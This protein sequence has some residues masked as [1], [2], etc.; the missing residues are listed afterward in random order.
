MITRLAKLAN[1]TIKK[2]NLSVLALILLYY[3]LTEHILKFYLRF[4]TK[5]IQLK[6]KQT[7]QR[8]SGTHSMK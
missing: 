5:E 4:N 7:T 6:C 8:F 2:A 3:A 1:D